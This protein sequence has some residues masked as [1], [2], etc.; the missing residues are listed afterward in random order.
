MSEQS[1]LVGTLLVRSKGDLLGVRQYKTQQTQFSC[2]WVVY[3]L[4]EEGVT[5]SNKVIQINIR[6]E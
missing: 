2:R 5:N 3:S 4:E 1:G 6:R